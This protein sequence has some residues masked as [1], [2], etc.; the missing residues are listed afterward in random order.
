M[1]E[2]KRRRPSWKAFLELHEQLRSVHPSKWN[3]EWASLP[4]TL[5]KDRQGAPIY[6]K[7]GRN[8]EP[9]CVLMHEEGNIVAR[10]HR[11]GFWETF[12]Y[13]DVGQLA[14]YK[15]SLG[16]AVRQYWGAVFELH[17][18]EI[19]TGEHRWVRVCYQGRRVLYWCAFT[20]LY[21]D[22]DYV[23]C[24]DDLWEYFA[25]AEWGQRDEADEVYQLAV[26]YPATTVGRLAWRLTQ[27]DPGKEA[28]L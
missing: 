26:A 2:S 18:S 10:R 22:G 27:Y 12:E 25:F 1:A 21:K 11:T 9:S 5:E 17:P 16:A 23:F 19:H 3:I 8:A 20:G 24:R 4:K 28:R 7:A 13:T 15:N 6:L 14:V